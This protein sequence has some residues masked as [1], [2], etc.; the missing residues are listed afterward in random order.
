MRRKK[1][2]SW[3]R[4]LTSSFLFWCGK[5]S[6]ATSTPEMSIWRYHQPQLQPT[7][8]GEGPCGQ[9]WKLPSTRLGA[10]QVE[11][12]TTLCGSCSVSS[13]KFHRSQKEATNIDKKV[14][15]NITLIICVHREHFQIWDFPIPFAFNV[16]MAWTELKEMMYLIKI[17]LYIFRTGI[18]DPNAKTK[19]KELIC[20]YYSINNPVDLS[21]E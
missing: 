10:K 15:R 6:G 3:E 11:W 14:I 16:W 20:I 13:F 9:T 7:E 18:K 21:S 8:E 19:T 2:S 12:P 17:L 1:F 5:E 4:V